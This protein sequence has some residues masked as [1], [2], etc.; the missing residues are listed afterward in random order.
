MHIEWPHAPDLSGAG[1]YS[2]RKPVSNT[3]SLSWTPVLSP[4]AQEENQGTAEK[5]GQGFIPFVEF[6]FLSED[7][8]DGNYYFKY[9]QEKLLL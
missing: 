4:A 6:N 9:L 1:I 8:T 2:M 3:R 7:D 5:I